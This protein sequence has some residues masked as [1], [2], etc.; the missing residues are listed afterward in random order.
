[1]G[2]DAIKVAEYTP[3]GKLVQHYESMTELRE[4]YYGGSKYPLWGVHPE[5][6]FLKNGNLVTRGY[7]G[8]DWLLPEL[9]KFNDPYKLKNATENDK[10]YVFNENNQ[11]IAVF[12]N[13]IIAKLLLQVPGG[14][15]YHDIN[16]SKDVK[17][18]NAGLYFRTKVEKENYGYEEK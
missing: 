14:T 18:T 3:E 12:A 8:R 11:E 5:I 13:M 17:S 7:K 6:H 4:K 1:M 2:R 16:F 15:M 9:R 10:I